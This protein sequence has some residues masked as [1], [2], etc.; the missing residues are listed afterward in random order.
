MKRNADKRKYKKMLHSERRAETQSYTND[1]HDALISKSGV[2]FWKC[3]RSKFEKVNKTSR[4]IDGLADDTQMAEMFAEF[5]RKTCT[6]FNEDQSNRLRS[7]FSDKRQK[8]VGDPLLREYKFDVELV[9]LC[10]R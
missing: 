1:L 2:N 3:W 4:L 8:Y 10:F 5:F 7:V 9:E 6:S